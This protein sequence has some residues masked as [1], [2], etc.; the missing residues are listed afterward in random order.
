MSVVGYVG[1]AVTI[2]G[3]IVLIASAFRVNTSWGFIALFMMPVS[4]LV[5][6]LT[7]WRIGRDGFILVVLGLLTISYATLTSDWWHE[8][9]YQKRLALQQQETV[10]GE[11]ETTEQSDV[12][13][14]VAPT[15]LHE[16]SE[17]IKP[18][19]NKVVASTDK[20]QKR[21][22]Q[23]SAITQPPAKDP[24][25]KIEPVKS[26]ATVEK[27][28][29]TPPVP[30]APAPTTDKSSTTKQIEK[31]AVTQAPD[32]AAKKT[33]VSSI[34]NTRPNTDPAKKSN[35]KILVYVVADITNIKTYVGKNVR[36]T[37]ITGKV[38]E[39]VLKALR[40]KFVVFEKFY[41]SGGSLTFELPMTEIKKLE[42]GSWKIRA[43]ERGKETRKKR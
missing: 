26:I 20:T 21:T 17:P 41:G 11:Q 1:I 33:Q 4:P 35:T 24:A 37:D 5:F 2:F 3:L 32:E 8:R 7:H 43:E 13:A 28:T 23:E 22:G 12:I 42:I 30:K 19:E 10:A 14:Q 38:Q 31:E 16:K 40:E 6:A 27:Q 18:V 9:Q 25:E 15:D 29:A 39:A 34:P 36:I